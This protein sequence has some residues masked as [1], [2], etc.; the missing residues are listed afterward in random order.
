[1]I[2]D[3]W[4]IGSVLPSFYSTV[5]NRNTA[6]C[7]LNA[8]CIFS[9]NIRFYYINQPRNILRG[10]NVGVPHQKMGIWPLK[11]LQNPIFIKKVVTKTFVWPDSI[12]ERC[13]G[14]Q[15]PMC[16]SFS[17]QYWRKL[18]FSVFW[19][20]FMG[21]IPIIWWVTAI[22]FHWEDSMINLS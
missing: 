11:G 15:N 8:H 5:V 22:F 17:L 6:E 18:R 20:C 2:D 12:K 21:Q 13:W 10:K 4:Q 7:C 3:S 1:M 9:L 16:K 14:S 19:R